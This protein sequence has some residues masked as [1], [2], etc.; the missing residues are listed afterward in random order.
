MGRSKNFCAT[1]PIITTLTHTTECVWEIAC[2]TGLPWL[3]HAVQIF[4]NWPVTSLGKKTKQQ[5]QEEEEEEGK[6]KWEGK[7]ERVVVVVALRAQWI[8]THTHTPKCICSTPDLKSVIFIQPTLSSLFSLSSLSKLNIASQ[9]AIHSFMQQA[10]Y[11]NPVFMHVC[12]SVRVCV[13]VR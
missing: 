13:C 3:M 11:W 6:E 5:A 4:V 12:L 2:Y 9:P 1:H 8:Y 7:R 10:L